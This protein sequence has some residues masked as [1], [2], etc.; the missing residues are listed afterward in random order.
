MSTPRETLSS[1]R[2][3]EG[4]LDRIYWTCPGVSQGS[5]MSS[6]LS[7]VTPVLGRDP[8]DRSVRGTFYRSLGKGGGTSGTVPSGTPIGPLSSRRSPRAG[9]D[10]CR[11]SVRILYTGPTP[12]TLYPVSESLSG[13]PFPVRER[14]RQPT[15]TTTSSA[16]R[17]SPTLGQ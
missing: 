12:R 14:S 13:A 2:T 5:S 10:D 11:D 9:T 7:P 15:A 6:T 4:V 8:R 1:S 3:V 16:V 17:P